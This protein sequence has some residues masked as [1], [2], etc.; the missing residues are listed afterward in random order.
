MSA[1]QSDPF[2]YTPEWGLVVKTYQSDIC[3]NWINTEW[4]DGDDGINKITAVAVED[5]LKA[6]QA[7]QEEAAAKKKE[8]AEKAAEKT[9]QEEEKREQNRVSAKIEIS[10]TQIN[11]KIPLF[12]STPS[13]VS[14][15]LF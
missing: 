5:D 13:H 8:E 1:S 14:I 2:Y 7:K 3:Q 4:I 9:R 10:P 15:P 6:A 12:S 11:L